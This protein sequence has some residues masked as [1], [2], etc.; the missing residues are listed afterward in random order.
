MTE[1]PNPDES[2][3]PQ[4]L[5]PAER[6][7]EPQP[8]FRPGPL[9]RYEP[10]APVKPAPA[11]PVVGKT[12]TPIEPP[13][14]EPIKPDPI[15]P[16]WPEPYPFWDY[17]DVAMFFSLALPCLVLSLLVVKGIELIL[18]VP[19]GKAVMLLPAQFIGYALWF[20]SLVALL[21][22]KYGKPFW[23]SL[24]WTM[25]VQGFWRAVFSG[26]LLAF[27]IALIGLALRTPT[28]EMPF[29]DLLTDRVSLVL[30]GIFACTLGPL[31]EEL[32]FRGFLLPLLLRS[33]GRLLG[34]FLSALPFA[35]LHGPQYSWSWHHLLL[36]TL[37]GMSFGWVR[38]RTGSTFAA[39]M[40]HAT[41]NLTYFS[42]FLAQR[43]G[44]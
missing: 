34:L 1:R 27:Y 13:V 2:R 24:A 6:S 36:L 15:T 30:T 42:A 41:Y 38:V 8:D 17:S 26:P 21:R 18:P 10:G 44:F 35:L 3:D 23:R 40:T 28:I 20:S 19:T 16:F 11:S 25:P 4:A 29:K 12:L 5:E 37:A 22:I 39:T 43:G 9:L 32:A 31:C 7:P 14:Q 33:F